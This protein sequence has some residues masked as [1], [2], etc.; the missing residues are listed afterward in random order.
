MSDPTPTET[1]SNNRGTQDELALQLASLLRNSLNLPQTPS[2]ESI[3]IGFKLNGDNYPLWSVLIKKAI[4]GRGKASYITG[5]PPAPSST[6][7]SY[8]RWEQEDQCVFTWL[9]QNIEPHLINSVSK[10]STSKVV[11][12]S[13][14]L[15]YGS[16]TDSLQVFDLHRKANTMK[17][18]RRTLEEIWAQLQEVWMS[19]DRREPN[20]MECK[21][22]IDMY[23]QIIQNRRVYQFLMALDENYE[24]IKKKILKREPLP[25]VETAYSMTKRTKQTQPHRRRGAAAVA[26]TVDRVAD[27]RAGNSG[28]TGTRQQG[29]AEVTAANWVE[30]ARVSFEEGKGNGDPFSN[31]QVTKLQRSPHSFPALQSSPRSYKAS[32]NQHHIPLLKDYEASALKMDDR[33]SKKINQWI[34]DCGATDTMTFDASDIITRTQP[35]KTH[36]QTANGELAP[37]LSTGTINLS[38]TLQLLNCLFVPSLS[39]K[40]LSISHVT[41]ELNCTLLMQPHFCLLQDIRTGAII[42]R[43]TERSGLYYVDDISSKGTVMLTHGSGNREAWLW[44]RRLGHPSCVFIGYGVHQKGYRC[45]DPTSRRLFTTM[46]C[47]FLE[48]EYFYHHLRSQGESVGT[49][50]SISWLTIDPLPNAEPESGPNLTKEVNSAAEK[51][52]DA[53]IQS[54]NH[55]HDQPSSPLLI[56]EVQ[57]SVDD[58]SSDSSLETNENDRTGSGEETGSNSATNK[59]VEPQTEV[60]RYV[61]PPRSTRR[62]PPKRFSPEHEKRKTQYSVG[63]Y[64]TGNLTDMARAFEAAILREPS[65]P[66]SPFSSPLLPLTAVFH[67]CYNS[68]VLI[69]AAT[70]LRYLL[71]S[72][73][74]NCTIRIC[75]PTVATHCHCCYSSQ[76]LLAVTG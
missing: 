28:L 19:I 27:A 56:F 51:R 37:V 67:R 14:A 1:T 74:S 52:S 22:D 75:P 76:L 32:Q 73:I 17:Q 13:L 61:L 66:P 16:G 29:E 23:N 35:L 31:S 72:L 15:T 45:Y 2:T 44:H 20:P 48:G 11:W 46:N 6:D 18:E 47:D 30:A 7:S 39:H 70:Q 41:K 12:D 64:S 49:S 24:P 58:Y 21:K 43:G 4:G 65:P 71:G 50:D 8:P 36:V 25:S 62:I 57:N 60:R 42:G 69:T 63:N 33:D 59:E 54:A 38:S 3:N 9:V 26:T 34:F 5:S 53:N 55:S 40:L 68:S 10:H